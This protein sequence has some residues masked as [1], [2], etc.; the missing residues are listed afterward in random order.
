MVGLS[1][2]YDQCVLRGDPATKSFCA[3]YFQGSRLLAMDAINRP[4][5]HMLVKRSLAEPLSLNPSLLADES[6]PLKDILA[7]AEHTIEGN[8]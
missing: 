2:G 6:I 5:D 1:E 7:G 4:R 8:P 3:F